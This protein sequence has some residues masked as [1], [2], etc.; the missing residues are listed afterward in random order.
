MKK[1]IFTSVI[2][3]VLLAY[4]AVSQEVAISD[5][6]SYTASPS[7]MLDVKSFTKGLLIPRLTTTQMNAIS[8]PAKGLM[9]FVTTDSSFYFYDG[10][11][12][13]SLLSSRTPDG[14]WTVS[15][16]N[17]S[18]SV[19]GNVGIGT[20]SPAQKLDVAGTVQVTGFA[21][22]TNPGSGLVLTSDASGN[23]TWQPPQA[24]AYA[25]V[26]TVAQSGGDFS[27]ITAAL[28][29]C[30]NPS[31]NNRYLVRVMPGT[32]IENIT[33][34]K[35]VTLQG[36]GKYSTHIQGV[37][38]GADSCTIQGLY[39][40]AG[41]LCPGVSPTIL[42][43]I[44]TNGGGTGILITNAGIPWIMENEIQDCVMGWGIHCNGWGVDPWIIGNKIERN[45]LGGIR[46]TN[47]CPVISNNLIMH[48]NNYGIYLIGAMNFPAEPTISDNQ[49]WH[50]DADAG[51]R[52]IFM[53]GYS[54][55]RIIGNDIAINEI[56]IE[57][58]PHTQP[59]IIA[60]VINYNHAYGIICSSSGASRPVT[61]TSNHVHSNYT[62]GV[63]VLYASPIITHNNI[64]ANIGGNDIEYFGPPTPNISLN[65]FDNSVPQT[66][67]FANG[68][69]NVDSNGNPVNP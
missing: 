34:L 22:P 46:C 28:S 35:F 45:E 31:A 36:A 68:N 30:I 66:G 10:T 58:Q 38:T 57:I 64:N 67:I 3:L 37:V 6:A 15:G 2:T 5:D 40:D 24:V 61:I 41:I 14:D 12:W 8:N 26:F 43:N 47:A 52:G 21:M 1:F 62:C 65:V 4:T 50:N 32:Y 20:T 9:V 53:M 29:A 56:G 16:T 51:G 63:Q 11:A 19:P 7:A 39:I 27:S 48:N 54:E 69:Y 44:I 25:Q 59:S 55:P 23:G 49:I 33:C 60:N 18:S 13:I 42:N 17:M